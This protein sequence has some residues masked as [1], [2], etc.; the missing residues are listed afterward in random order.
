MKLNQNG[1]KQAKVSN[2]RSVGKAGLIIIV[3]VLAVIITIISQYFMTAQ[4]REVVEI[5]T[6][7]SDVDQGTLITEAN[8]TKK[9][10]LAA[11]YL[12]EAEKQ[13]SDGTKRRAI[14]LWED[15]DIV[16]NS[17]V[18]AS[19]FMKANTPIYW[20][21]L[22]TESPRKNSYLYEMDGE[23]IKLSV[24][25]DVFGD[26]IVPGDKVN[27]RCLYT[28][29]T[30]NLPTV[31][32]Y[33]AMKQLGIETQKSEE[34]MI[35][36]F[37]EVTILD[38]LNGNGESIFDY[39]YEFITWPLSKQ[40]AALESDEFKSATAPSEILL[41]VTSEEAD[42]YMRIQNKGPQYMLTLLPRESSSV[43]LEALSSLNSSGNF[44]A[45]E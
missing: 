34:K 28:E 8:L 4:Q 7:A 19:Y 23:L 14:I 36:L 9:D 18:Y 29:T 10:M 11:E 16:L 26:M 44:T 3:I 33:Q 1:V 15:R 25:A 20:S 39:Y 32:E 12:K 45:S 43:I 17:N 37:S 21:S 35:M 5:L 6:F 2:Q 38:M 27:I 31:Q 41:C 42:Q 40:R 13:L 30:Y 22:T 24:S